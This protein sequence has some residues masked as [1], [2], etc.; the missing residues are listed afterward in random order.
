[1]IDS[2]LSTGWHPQLCSGAQD[3]PR[4]RLASY[5]TSLRLFTNNHIKSI[6]RSG[7][8]VKGFA[9]ERVR[10]ASSAEKL[11]SINIPVFS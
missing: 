11:A 9:A 8:K 5:S 10:A 6:L 4:M 1:M 2:T 3:S 7:K